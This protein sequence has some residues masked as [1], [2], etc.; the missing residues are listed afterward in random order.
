MERAI[1]IRPP[2]DDHDLAALERSLAEGTPEKHRDRFARQLLGRVTYL[3]AWDGERPVGHL[4]IKWDGPRQEPM[5][6][7]LPDCPELED[8]YID[9]HYRGRR[10]G[11]RLIE[12][13]EALAR[14]R[15]YRRIGLSVGLTPDYDRAR[16]IYLRRGY[17]GA[18]FAPY[19]EGWWA[20]DASGGRVWWEEAVEY[21]VKPLRAEEDSDD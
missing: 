14:T 5:R 20:I 16:A 15:G 10:I 11:L 21:L 18:G 12:A 17:R 4:L 13:A 8:Y 3:V 7:A 2:I 1:E 9:P 6:S 19:Y